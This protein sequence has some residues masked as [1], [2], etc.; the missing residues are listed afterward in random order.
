MTWGQKFRKLSNQRLEE[1]A[2]TEFSDKA[3]LAICR[4]RADLGFNWAEIRPSRPVNVSGTLA[5]SAMRDALGKQQLRLEW[6]PIQ[7]DPDPL[8]KYFALRVS[9]EKHN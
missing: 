9:W 6:V 7:E 1:L 4:E 2:E 8:R 5:A 3:V